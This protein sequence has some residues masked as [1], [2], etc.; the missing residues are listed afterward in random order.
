M[1]QASRSPGAVAGHPSGL[2]KAALVAGAIFLLWKTARGAR[3]LL[4][5]ALGL[6]FV[7][8]WTGFWPW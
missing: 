4:W 5:G 2:W 3:D 7:A 8:W 6:G 1:M